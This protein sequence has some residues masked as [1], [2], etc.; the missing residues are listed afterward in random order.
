MLI[1]LDWLT[2]KLL[3]TLACTVILGSES[4]ESHDHVLLSDDSRSLHNTCDWIVKVMLRTTAS[5]PVCLGV[6]HPAGSQDKIFISQTAE[7]LLMLVAIFDVRTDLSF[8]IAAGPRQCSHCGVRIPQ[9]SRTYFIASDC[10]LPQP[11]GPGPRVYIPR[12][13][14]AQ[15]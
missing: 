2:A 8:T 6:K 7:G 14:V 13:R 3:L 15:L 4:H 5:W 9:D 11:G 1:M 10:R 12:N